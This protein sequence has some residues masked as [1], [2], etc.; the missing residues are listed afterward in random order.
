MFVKKGSV[1]ERLIDCIMTINDIL[2]LLHTEIG[3]D[4]IIR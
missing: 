2:P 1:K 3:I 4:N